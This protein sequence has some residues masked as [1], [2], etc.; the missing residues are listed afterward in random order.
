MLINYSQDLPLYIIGNGVVVDGLKEYI[1]EE[2]TGT[3]ETILKEDYYALPDHSQVIVG[4]WNYEY[5]LEFFKTAF[6]APMRWIS[7][8]HPMAF[9][10]ESA[11]IG[12]G[13]AVYPMATISN[14]VIVKDQCM[15]GCNTHIGHGTT[16]GFNNLMAP[17]TIIGGSTELGDNIY[18]GM[19]NSIKDKIFVCDNVK[20]NMA[21]RVSK[22]V[23]QSG[24]YDGNRRLHD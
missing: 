20:F 13:T 23:S 7:Y 21:S 14:D 9:V 19:N 16:L 10:A 17:G 5:R 12:Q 8:I 22:N 3:I 11:H 15:I 24:T 1:A 6:L 18:M 4:F 2:T